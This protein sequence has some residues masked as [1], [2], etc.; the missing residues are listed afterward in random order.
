MMLRT[1]PPMN[2]IFLSIDMKAINPAEM[3]QYLRISIH[4]DLSVTAKISDFQI[5][6]SPVLIK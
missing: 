1:S 5:I 2:P 6:M 3:A 4:I